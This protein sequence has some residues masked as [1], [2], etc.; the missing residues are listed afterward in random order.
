[1]SDRFTLT[2]VG[3]RN[4]ICLH[5]VNLTAEPHLR[6]PAIGDTSH[7][8]LSVIFSGIDWDHRDFLDFI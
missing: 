7:V 8:E 5:V 1:M 2:P 3:K 6:Q 4:K